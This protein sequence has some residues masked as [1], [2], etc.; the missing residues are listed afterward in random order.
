ME[1]DNY[2]MATSM[3]QY[4]EEM[5]KLLN[6]SNSARTQNDLIPADDQM[7]DNY[8]EDSVQFGYS[9]GRELVPTNQIDDAE[10]FPL[11]NFDQKLSLDDDMGE[12]EHKNDEEEEKSDTPDQSSTPTQKNGFKTPSTESKD[13]ETGKTKQKLSNKERARRARQRKK[14]YY[15]DLEKRAEYLEDKATKMA[16]E[17]E[18]LKHKLRFYEN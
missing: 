3:L 8:L 12:G 18:Y 4:L 11:D 17:I 16:K 9:K 14:K 1:N 2:I 6:K 15:E 5:D 7:E 10:G 13:D